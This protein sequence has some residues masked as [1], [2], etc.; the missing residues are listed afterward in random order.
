MKAIAVDEE[1]NEGMESAFGGLRVVAAR[2]SPGLATGSFSATDLGHVGV[3]TL[4]GT[5]QQLVRSPRTLVQTPTENLKICAVR[6][7][8]CVIEQSGGVLSVGPGELGVYD[9]RRPYRLNW[10]A[11]WACEVM[12]TPPDLLG[13]TD[14]ALEAA[15]EKTW[16]TVKGAGSMLV[17]FMDR[18][19]MQ[20]APTGF[21]RNHLA[22]AGT[23][24]LT[25]AI[26]DDAEHVAADS[27]DLFRER[28]EA[29]IENSL[30]LPAL[31]PASIAAA[32]HISVRTL[33]RLFGGA[34]RGVSGLIRRRRLEAVRRD[35]RNPAFGSHTIA[36]VAARWCLHDAQWL[37]KAFKAEFGVSPSEFRADAASDG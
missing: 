8:R 13:L 29:F 23:S 36:A 27:A 9:T 18:C 14:R 31:G 16:S 24:L 12:T 7:G 28:V 35:L 5:P 30:Q 3:F 1:W 26:L 33:Q 25:A 4:S 21:A 15:R 2:D 37:A 20:P 22:Q 6:R 19:S 11:D 17:D 10:S 32:H 34:D